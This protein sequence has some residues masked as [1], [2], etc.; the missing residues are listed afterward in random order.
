MQT[1]KRSIIFQATSPSAHRAGDIVFCFNHA[2]DAQ[3]NK[4][5]WRSS[6]GSTQIMSEH[7]SSLH[8]LSAQR[9]PV[10]I[11]SLVTRQERTL[12]VF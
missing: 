8:T 5:F 10:F 7:S 9:L 12:I 1:K 4:L 6:E 3:A 11:H 2:T